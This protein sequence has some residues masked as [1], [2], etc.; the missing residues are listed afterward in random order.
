VKPN[1]QWDSTAQAPF[2]YYYSANSGRYRMVYFENPDSLRAKYRLVKDKEL[3][4]V[5]I[6]ALGYD[7]GYQELWKLLGKEFK[8]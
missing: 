3:G 6:W 4:G 8:L 7:G 2:F 1:I 5:G